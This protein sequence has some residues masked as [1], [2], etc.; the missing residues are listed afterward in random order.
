MISPMARQPPAVTARRYQRPVSASGRP[1][2]LPSRRPRPRRSVGGMLAA[3]LGA[4]ASM[5]VIAALALAGFVDADGVP[6]IRAQAPQIPREVATD[7]GL[8]ATGPLTPL[9]CRLPRIRPGQD[10]SMHRF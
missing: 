5:L 9:R 1:Y 4:I 8:Y 6:L 3:A 7:N 2:A 10:E